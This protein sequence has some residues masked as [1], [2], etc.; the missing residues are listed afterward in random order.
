MLKNRLIP[1][2]FLKHGLLVRSQEFKFH[3]DLGNPI[4]Q[5]ERYNSWCVD[6]L[7]Y[8]DISPEGSYDL[9]R[10][11]MKIKSVPDILDIITAVS[12]TCF[13]PLTFGGRIRTIEDIRERVKRGADKV[14]INTKAIEDPKFITESSEI[15]G[16]QCIVISIDVKKKEDESYEVYS[17]RGKKPTG[18][19]PVEWAQ[20]A[21]N[22]GAGEIFLNSINRD[23]TGEGYDIEL[24]KS[25]AEAVSIPLIACGGVGNYE[26]F[27]AVI[28]DGKA[29]AAAAGNIFNFREHSTILAKKHMYDRGLNVRKVG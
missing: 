28:K 26:D 29:D 1:C 3:Q 19:C 12:K 22:L 23:G 20:K 11:D 27:V 9:R 4:H 16:S 17:H 7:I 25:V 21:E 14:T 6:E 18:M 24:V 13:M 5:V 2:L 8:I 10:D 15:F